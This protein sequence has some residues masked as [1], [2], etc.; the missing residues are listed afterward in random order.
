MESVGPNPVSHGVLRQFNYEDLVAQILT[1]QVLPLPKL[2]L[3]LSKE[4][5]RIFQ[6]LT[7]TLVNATVSYWEIQI[8]LPK[9]ISPSNHE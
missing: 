2:S 4:I 8:I 1:D 6:N 7:N 5:R 3:C 9:V